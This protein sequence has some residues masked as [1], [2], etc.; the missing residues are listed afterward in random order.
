MS[1]DERGGRADSGAGDSAQEETG[2]TKRSSLGGGLIAGA[3][4]ALELAGKLGGAALR[5]FLAKPPDA[6]APAHESRGQDE[7]EGPGGEPRHS[8]MNQGRMDD[9]NLTIEKEHK[10]FTRRRRGTFFVLCSFGVS[11]AGGF[12][13]LFIYWTGGSN[14]LLGANLAAFFAGLGAGMVWWA[15][16]LTVHKEAR[17]PR[18]PHGSPPEQQESAATQFELGTH[19]IHRR[20]LLCWMSAIG[21]GFMATMAVSLLRSFGFNPYTALY[22]TVWKAGQR[23]VT[24]DGRPISVNAMPPGSTAIVFPEDS[25]G[26]E[27]SQTVLIRVQPGLLQL[28]PDRADW[29]PQ[30]YLAYS[31][32]CTHAGCAV[33]MYEK[34]AHLLMCP[35]HQSTFNILRA[36]QPTGGPA[37]RPLPQLPLYVDGQGFLRAAGGFSQNPGPG[38]WGL[39]T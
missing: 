28:P 34:T 32:I 38:F 35:C 13:F 8:E 10:L 33:G 1:A 25:T 14:Q 4:L 27:K 22:T 5:W 11:F 3:V 2:K 31:R 17:E 24:Q 39:Q 20:G 12:G 19:E 26:S 29:A 30:G 7:S 21:L 6:L 23:L 18:E 37:A 16:R 36:A 15:H 9:R